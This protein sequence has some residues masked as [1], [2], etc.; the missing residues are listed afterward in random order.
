[1]LSEVLAS[2]GAV[3]L[4]DQGSKAVVRS[5]APQGWSAGAPLL[6]IRFV[7]HR[8]PLYEL[9][10]GRCGLVLIWV[11]ALSCG[12]FLHHSGLLLQSKAALYGLSAALGGAAGN[13]LDILRHRY[14][15]DFI[16]L[17]WWPVFNFADLAIIF[18]L[19]AAVCW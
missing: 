5:H 14:V 12:A 3:L 19:I 18:G 13:L 11:T 17:G 8:L 4:A 1:M 6:K 10:I 2:G 7:A 16:D 9:A 15:V